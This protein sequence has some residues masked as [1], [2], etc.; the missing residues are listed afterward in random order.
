MKKIKK[1]IKTTLLGGVIVLLPVLLAG[2]FLN[3]LYNFITELIAPL[4]IVVVEKIKLHKIVADILVILIIVAICFIVGLV[5]KTRLGRFFYRQIEKRI[6]KIMPGYTL[7]RNTIKQFLGQE[8]APFSK[9]ALVQAFGNNT[10]MTGFVTDENSPNRV[11]VFVPSG[12]NPT[13]GLI[14]HLPKEHVHLIDVSV[15]DTMRSIISCGAGSEKLVNKF[16]DLN[17]HT[18]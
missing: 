15:E 18:K 2:F 8:K 12:L 11:T 1:F 9:V 6:L 14:F 10:L 3:W 7:F 4:T 17:E 5:V 13:S 16:K